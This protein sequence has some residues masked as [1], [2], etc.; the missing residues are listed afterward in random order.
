MRLAAWIALLTVCL[1]TLAHAQYPPETPIKHVVVIVQ[2][3]RTPDNLFQGL[4]SFGAGWEM[5]RT[6]TTSA[7]LMYTTHKRQ[8]LQP[9]GLA[10]PFEITR[11]KDRLGELRLLTRLA[12][13]RLVT[14][15]SA[16]GR[17]PPSSHYV[18]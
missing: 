17:T 14:T 13:A 18:G 10:T 3:N 4:C 9:V 8:P 2:E 6:S 12:T 7:Q 5:P 11:G 15:T 1:G 16:T